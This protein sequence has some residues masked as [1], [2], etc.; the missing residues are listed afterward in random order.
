MEKFNNKCGLTI[1]VVFRDGILFEPKPYG[2][3]SGLKHV[4]TEEV[5]EE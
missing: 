2:F 1:S 5:F 4:E 3:R